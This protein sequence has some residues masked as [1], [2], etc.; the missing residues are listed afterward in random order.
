M[1]TQRYRL[2]RLMSLKSW[3]AT[4][5]RLLS[6]WNAVSE[7]FRYKVWSSTL[8]C[9]YYTDAF[10]VSDFFCLAALDKLSMMGSQANF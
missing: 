2:R 4:P 9:L 5:E 7:W 8:A 3:H 10:T 6:L 1:T